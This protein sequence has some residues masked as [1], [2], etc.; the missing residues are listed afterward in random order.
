L[1]HPR[2]T[3]AD[4]DE[5][6]NEVVGAVHTDGFL[7]MIH[8]GRGWRAEDVLARKRKRFYGRRERR[9]EDEDDE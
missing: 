8:P 4:E 5:S 2:Y 1:V 6:E 3:D 7:K 9:D